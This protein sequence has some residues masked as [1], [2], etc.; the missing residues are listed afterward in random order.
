MKSIDRRL[1]LRYALQSAAALGIEG[2]VLGRLQAA[3]AA[4][5]SGLPT[6]LWLAGGACTGCTVSLANRVSSTSPKDLG[7]LLLNGIDLRFHPNLMGAAGQLAVDELMDASSQ[8]GYVLAIEGSIPT[9]FGGHA[10]VVWSDRGRDVTM[11][12]AV[13]LLAPNAAAVLAIGTCASFGG[14]SSAYPNPAGGR[15]VRSFTGAPVINLPGCPTH[16]DWIVW[17]IAQLLAGVTPTL[18]G[19]GRPIA[20]YSR[21]VHDRCPRKGTGEAK[22][23]AVEGC[24]KALGCK[25]PS[26]RADC[27]TRLWNGGTSWCVGANAECVGCTDPKFPDGWESIYSKDVV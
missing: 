10:C 8:S 2:S 22:T 21:S 11:A 5:G 13:Q 4:G 6:V 1:F 7:D 12:E 3:H 27:P 23:F 9:A 20:L 19:S 14:V 26:T 17:T 18:D 16:P 15:S 24:L 25:G